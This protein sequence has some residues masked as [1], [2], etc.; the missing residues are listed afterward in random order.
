MTLKIKRRGPEVSGHQHEAEEEE[1]ILKSTGFLQQLIR[2][3][4]KGV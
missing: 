4:F 1:N 3:G 2:L